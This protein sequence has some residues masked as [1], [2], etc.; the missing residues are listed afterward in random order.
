[1]SKYLIEIKKLKCH[2]NKYLKIY[3][4]LITK[5]INENPP[6]SEYAEE[7]HILPRSLC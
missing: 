4:Q 1:M 6:I 5:R 3:C 2:N 7:H